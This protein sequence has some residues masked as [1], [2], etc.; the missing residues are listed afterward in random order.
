[1]SPC[2]CCSGRSFEACCDLY[3]N[4]NEVAPDAETLMRSRYTA[5]SLARIDYIEKTMKAPANKGYDPIAAK[6]WASSVAWKY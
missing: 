3:L 2:P 1:M 5:Y 4:Q 6:Q